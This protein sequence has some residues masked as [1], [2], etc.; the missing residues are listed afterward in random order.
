MRLAEVIANLVRERIDESASGGGDE[1]RLIFHGPPLEILEKAFELLVSDGGLGV[2]VVLQLPV[3]EAGR[4]NPAVGSSGRC[5][6][7]HL[8]NLR[9]SPFRPTYV[10]LVPPGQHSN[11]SVETTSDDFGMR[12][13]N[14]GGNV[15]FETWWSDEFTQELVGKAIADA[16]L[17]DLEVRALVESAASAA[18]DVD[19]ERTLRAG[20]WRVVSRLFDAVGGAG[21]LSPATGVSLACG[22][23]P[24]A[25][26]SLSAA[27]QV[28]VL[29]KIA[30]TLA[31]GFGSGIE[32]IGA[33]GEDL[34]NLQM[35]RDH[36]RTSCDSPTGFERAPA[37]YYALAG[38]ALQP[39][40][41]WWSYLTVEKWCELLADESADTG[42]I[43]VTCANALVPPK[44]GM[45]VLV[46]REVRLSFETI[47]PTGERTRL[48]IERKPAGS[49]G[50]SI[51]EVWSDDAIGMVD[52]SIPP[53]ASPARYLVSASGYKDARIRVISLAS[54]RP[55]VFVTC[56]LATRLVPPKRGRSKNGADWEAGLHLP[57]AG[58]Y[59]LIVFT[60]PETSLEGEASGGSDEALQRGD[61][62]GILAVRQVDTLQAQIEVELDGNY[63]VD[64]P[65]IRT[66]PDGT[67]SRESCRVSITV[68][69]VQQQGCRSEFERL[70]GANRRIIQPALARALVV[71]DRNARAS[72][73]QEWLL[74]E[75]QSH[76]SYLPLVLAEDYVDAWVQPDWSDPDGPAP[77]SRARFIQ[78]PRPRPSEFSP[79]D[80]FVEARKGI[81]DRIR[82][83]GEQ[84]GLTESAELGRWIR[85]DAN[86]RDLVER[87]VS[88]Y[89]TWLQAE[90]DVA[91]W[92]D[93]VAITSR[94]Q[95][96]NLARVP[97][98]ILLSPLHP[99]RVAWH[100]AAQQ[101]LLEADEAGRPCP[102]ASVL[103]PDCVPDI[104][105]LSVRAPDGIERVD[106]L[107]VENGTDYWSVLWNG[108]ALG[109]L[110][111]RS[112]LPPFGTA[113]GVSVGGISAGFSAAQVRRAL[114]D[115]SDLLAAKPL[116]GVAVASAGG[117][118]D[119]CNQGLL[120]WCVERYHDADP[121]PARQSVGPRRLDIYDG[122]GDGSRPDD[123]TIANVCEDSGNA[124]RWFIRQPKDIVPDLGIIAQ[125]DMTEPAATPVAAR[126]AMGAGG[127][128]RHRVRR[129][130]PNAYLSESRRGIAPS[131]SGDAL[132]DKLGACIAA[133]EN[134]GQKQTG[135]R[136][137][138]NVG[139]IRR[140]LV[141]SRADFVA[142]SSSAVD[143]ACFLGGW[144]EGT[145][146]WDYD[147]P[148][149]SHRAGDT[150]GYYLLSRV[151]EADR[152][153][154][155]RAL[156]RL[157][158]CEKL[159]PAY[160]QDV[161]LEVARR[162][163]PT[164]RGLAGDNAGATG[165][166]GLFLA[167]RLLQDR[168]RMTGQGGSLLPVVGGAGDDAQL[169][170][171][172]PVDPF[173]GY[174]SD[175]AR[176]LDQKDASLS[177]PDLLVVGV[178][179]GPASVQLR[180]TPV[181]VKCRPGS[182]M[183]AG[184]IKAALE[185]AKAL[186]SLLSKMSS[187]E[188]SP[189]AWIIAF[190]H[191]LLSMIGFGMRVYSQQR[192]V[193]DQDRWAGF[194]ERIAASILSGECDISI[195]LRGRL[196]IVDNFATSRVRDNDGD[197]F[198]ETISISL[199]DAGVMV[200]GDP[201]D[202]YG[203]VRAKIFD[204]DLM[205]KA[206]EDFGGEGSKKEAPL[207]IVHVDPGDSIRG[208]APIH[209]GHAAP[210][211]HAGVG[212]DAEPPL[213]GS[214]EDE[215]LGIVLD[216]GTTVDGFQPRDILLNVSDTRLNHMNMGVVGDLGTGK[217][218]LLKSLI[219]QISGAT[220]SN[221]GIAPRFLIFD[222]KN[223]YSD[224]AFVAATG[225]K[226]VLPQ[227]LPLNLFDTSGVEG[228]NI[229]MQR[230][231]FFSDV[232]DKIY[233]GIGPV[234]RGKLKAAI[235][236]TYGSTLGDL[237]PTLH[238][239]REAYSHIVE[240]RPDS[241]LSVLGDLVDMDL[242]EADPRKTTSFDKF[243]DG[244][245]V[246]SLS[247]LGQDDRSKNML[248]AVMLNLFYENM[249][250][251]K[252]RPFVGTSPQL[253]AI[254]CY[255]LVDEA[256]NIMRYE[257]P[258][259]GKLL[260]QARE[261]GVGI[262]LAS[263]YLRHFKQ[264]GT[265]YREPLLTWFIHKVPNVT[266][267]ELSALGLTGPVGELAE[268]VK[269]LQNHQCLYKSFDVHGEVLRGLPF[270]EL[271]QGDGR[272]H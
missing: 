65:F 131:A 33:V 60:V 254:D 85:D 206:T 62:P 182:E 90:P 127:L 198:D 76:N 225:A 167:V 253:R 201:A 219:T 38:H 259:L 163:I 204:W 222:Y 27:E 3:L 128:I 75:K 1:V 153:A 184:E 45:P 178:R 64:I 215:P 120:D 74:S 55:G 94:D 218:Q 159:D 126:T 186:C 29:A 187:I 261:F 245:V 214:R 249:L 24:M 5:D 87:Y 139:A 260:L 100:C 247:A 138:P 252:K 271:V 124:V 233:P 195:D 119:T 200:A 262:I 118:T 67:I 48:R 221:R 211:E 166:L 86:F 103:D 137:A 267:A 207:D 191:L 47:G 101:V 92:V 83:A 185:Q 66:A 15:P 258:V 172:I 208:V 39:V 6:S 35:L 122:R 165:D 217:T 123:A 216:I 240:G 175:L 106:F 203:R 89:K 210:L 263:Q 152:D 135:M 20:A 241:I 117:T 77:L 96:G 40:P 220:Q 196:I 99:A 71:L 52:P 51:F 148:S 18:D 212:A 264:G 154:L 2:P 59:E 150:N 88:T 72:S 10:A 57:G 130:L 31:D 157:P 194:H 105:T 115:V 160:V 243:L 141:E 171:I 116:I 58:R 68:E 230:Y 176:S 108:Q 129:Q 56:R 180:L 142:V 125:L 109:E 213:G 25:D 174:L 78:D 97:Q 146:L 192:D 28:R 168:F 93:V 227:N 224:P 17:P 202:F 22:V 98:S 9:N 197:G 151:K 145:F 114:V 37:A 234:Q 19:E 42:N 248:V 23:P 34:R 183:P 13:A 228:V 147:L 158:G 46:E 179:I 181:E 61:P 269:S 112:Q 190:Q 82:G 144:L 250:R 16:Q 136:F 177:R 235:Q 113:F 104:L 44:K 95:G 155:K 14:N 164:I 209:V 133:I 149:Y 30:D 170:L 121:Q 54:W 265:D 91:C 134:M 169:C 36:L 102:A 223:D 79:P 26:G 266:P 238:D 205:P 236:S 84:A 11:R 162:G 156:S 41:A 272:R 110:P 132:L 255:L 193:L 81:A 12:S 242:F 256:D 80:G 73:L 173:R 268:R 107:A 226:V 270:F 7:T 244:V 189:R 4:A 140:M 111:K 8:L 50:R 63:Q 161:L 70:I 232:L 188:G 199:P 43:V 237:H 231:R 239:V 229:P 251:I 32:R 143:P 69:D 21:G 53:H 49:G 246:I 257:F